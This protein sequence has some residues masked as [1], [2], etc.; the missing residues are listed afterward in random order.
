MDIPPET[1]RYIKEMIEHSFDLPV[2]AS[3]L[4]LKLLASK[5]ARLRLRNKKNLLEKRL[6]ENA[7]HLDQYKAEATMSAQGLKRC[8]EE[9]ESVV[10]RFVELTDQKDKLQKECMLYKKDI[11]RLIE[12]CDFF[13]KENEELRTKLNV[14]NNV[15]AICY[16]IESLKK[17]KEQLRNNLFKAEEEVELIFEENKLLEREN[18]WVHK[19]VNKEKR[20][21]CSGFDSE[22]GSITCVKE[23]ET[24]VIPEE[25]FNKSV[26]EQMIE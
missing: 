4:S 25:G 14:C 9:K 15:I 7:T 10:T 11:E 21:G 5:D 13:R 16:E 6:M 8:V 17:D 18:K 2:S 24:K 1:D 20:E 26:M 19:Q 3:T 23:R 12:S 22:D